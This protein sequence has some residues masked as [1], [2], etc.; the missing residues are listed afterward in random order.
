MQLASNP[1]DIRAAGWSVSGHNDY[2]QD[3]A[4]HTYW[5][6]V[7]TE[8]GAKIGQEVHGEGL[9]DAEAL[10]SIRGKLGLPL[11]V[12]SLAAP[13]AT[14]EDFLDWLG[15]QNEQ[16]LR[17]YFTNTFIRDGAYAS[18][19]TVLDPKK[20]PIN[21]VDVIYDGGLAMKQSNVHRCYTQLLHAVMVAL[22]K[23]EVD[24]AKAP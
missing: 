17:E 4:S 11:P 16:P 5:S 14:M 6:F 7:R 3:N 19:V 8:K 22:S 21:H 1:D 20:Y 24:A 12:P 9:T 18:H 23:R 13:W 2:R 10:N 15:L